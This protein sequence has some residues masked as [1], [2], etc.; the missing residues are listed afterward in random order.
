MT[1]SDCSLALC[2]HFKCLLNALWV[3]FN[4]CLMLSECSEKSSWSLSLHMIRWWSTWV[5][6]GV[7]NGPE[8]SYFSHGFKIWGNYSFLSP[9]WPKMKNFSVLQK[10]LHEDLKIHPLFL[11]PFGGSYGL[12]N[13]GTIWGTPCTYFSEHGTKILLK[14]CK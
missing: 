3:L 11:V 13:M 10:E 5:P 4:A 1:K 6:V 14:I 7:K 9:Q 2:L 8:R 12:S